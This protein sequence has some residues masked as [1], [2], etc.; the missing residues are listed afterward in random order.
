[1]PLA[2]E[3]EDQ[4][5]EPSRLPGPKWGGKCYMCSRNPLIPEGPSPF[6][7]SLLLCSL[8][9][10]PLGPTWPEGALEG[11]GTGL[12]AQQACWGPSLETQQA[13]WGPSGQG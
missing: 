13:S 1:M 6:T 12:E 3:V 10:M 7:S 5:W 2:S 8:P 4:V 9:P 11:W